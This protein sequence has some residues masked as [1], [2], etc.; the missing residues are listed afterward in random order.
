MELSE[1]QVNRCL[2]I[3]ISYLN[4][5]KPLLRHRWEINQALKQSFGPVL[6]ESFTG[7]DIHAARIKVSL[8]A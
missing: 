3:R 1:E 6:T 7:S 2:V 8:P 4:K 5:L